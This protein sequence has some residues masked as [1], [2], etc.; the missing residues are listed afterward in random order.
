MNSC[1]SAALAAASISSSRR[2]ERPVRDV[3]L[4]GPVEEER[5]LTDV[6]DRPPQTAEVYVPDVGAV[7]ANRP[8]LHV[9]HAEEEF[10]DGGFARAGGTDERERFPAFGAQIDVRDDGLLAVTETHVVVL[11]SAVRDFQVRRVGALVQRPAFV[12]QRVHSVTGRLGALVDVD[13]LPELRHGPDELLAQDDEG[14]EHAGFERAGERPRRAG[15]Q[16]KAA[17]CEGDGVADSGQ[18]AQAGEEGDSGRDGV[19]VRVVVVA[20]RLLDSA[21][22]VRFR[23]FGFDDANAAEV[24]LQSGVER[25]DA[26]PHR[27][28]LRL[29]GSDE[30]VRER[31]EERHRKQRHERERR[32]EGEQDAADADDEHRDAERRTQ[33]VVQKRLQLVHVVVQDG[34][35]LARLLAVEEVHVEQL[36]PVVGV[37]AELVLDALR[38]RVPAPAFQPRERRPDEERREDDADGE[39]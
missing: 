35:Q 11:D 16:P 1:A 3:L 26:R 25:A 27:G 28:V 15:E 23:G 9:V 37:H 5:F 8:L 38:E 39:P 17:D 30:E 29:D 18:E 22:F 12:H 31:R 24:V 4:H 20:G 21:G 10:Q 19:P 34:H 13:Y 14:D 6:T 7:D 32:I 36:H 33:P 2:V